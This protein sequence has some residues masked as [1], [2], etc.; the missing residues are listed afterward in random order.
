MSNPA[1][2]DYAR[3]RDRMR[4]SAILA[5]VYAF[6]SLPLSY[7]AV[8]NVDLARMHFTASRLHDE[9]LAREGHLRSY[10]EV[11]KARD[12]SSFC[13][14]TA[15]K[16]SF[17]A[18]GYALA[19]VLPIALLARRFFKNLRLKREGDRISSIEE[20]ARKSPGACGLVQRL[21]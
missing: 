12:Y 1:M 21:D 18:A 2:D 10:E 7:Q 5:G 15:V 16:E 14:R 3:A 19:V 4:S 20:I 8:N 13:Y 11:Q 6:A 17:A 9:H